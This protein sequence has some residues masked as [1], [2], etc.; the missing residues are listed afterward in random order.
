[1]IFVVFEKLPTEEI[2][3]KISKV[4]SLSQTFLPHQ[5]MPLK[6]K[7]NKTEKVYTPMCVDFCS[8][9]LSLTEQKVSK[10]S[11]L[12]AHFSQIPGLYF[13]PMVAA[14]VIAV[15]VREP[16]AHRPCWHRHQPRFPSL[17][18]RILCSTEGEHP[19][20]DPSYCQHAASQWWSEYHTR[21]PS[22]R[23]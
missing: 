14:G 18:W 11:F 8:S 7:Q 23:V 6:T 20:P 5:P 16:V 9:N 2:L 21:F 13:S 3:Q 10:S 22:N 15:A 1:M 17:L 12:L 4:K 19:S